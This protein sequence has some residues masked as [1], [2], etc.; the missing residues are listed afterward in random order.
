M[1]QFKST[2]LIQWS[3]LALTLMK[4]NSQATSSSEVESRNPVWRAHFEIY[5][6]E[7]NCNLQVMLVSE[8]S[9]PRPK[10]SLKDERNENLS[11][12]KKSKENGPSKVYGLVNLRWWWWSQNGHRLDYIKRWHYFCA[13]S[14]QFGSK[15]RC[16]LC[17]HQFMI[18]P[19]TILRDV[20]YAR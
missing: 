19:K 12:I 4:S 15:T 17:Y 9:A 1:I 16:T 6:L 5:L 18:C 13:K 7:S 2:V 11:L 8:S 14:T 20:Y 3:W 10:I